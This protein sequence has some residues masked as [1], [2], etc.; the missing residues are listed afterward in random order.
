[1]LL[2]RSTRMASVIPYKLANC[3]TYSKECNWHTYKP[4]T[5]QIQT[6]ANEQVYIDLSIPLYI[7]LRLCHSVILCEIMLYSV[8]LAILC[9]L[10]TVNTVHYIALSAYK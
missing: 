5:K 9:S 2:N 1:M 3:V 10:N 8:V 6:P 7:H 4:M